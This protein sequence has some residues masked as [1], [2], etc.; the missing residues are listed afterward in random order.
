MAKIQHMVLFKWKPG[1]TEDA[2][3][4]IFARL[5]TLE[6]VIPGIE[7]FG[8]GPYSSPEGYN[9]GYT[10]GFL[11]TFTDEQARDRYLPHPEHE[12]V[13]QVILQWAESV[14]AFDFED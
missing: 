9:Q 2:L 10:H 6:E 3:A 1:I 14:I 8:G 11:M 7:H 5:A 13:K 12:K 4:D